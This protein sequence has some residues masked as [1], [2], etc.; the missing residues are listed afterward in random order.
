M[1]ETVLEPKPEGIDSPSAAGQQ[2]PILPPVTEL[3]SRAR[4][5]PVVAFNPLG[6]PLPRRDLSLDM[7]A[8]A[9]EVQS[10]SPP[11]HI[12]LSSQFVQGEERRQNGK[13]PDSR[14]S[15]AEN[16]SKS[17]KQD[18]SVSNLISS[19]LN[20]NEGSQDPTHRDNTVREFQEKS[21]RTSR[22]EGDHSPVGGDLTQSE[23]SSESVS[24]SDRVADDSEDEETS[25]LIDAE[26]NLDKD[27][28][29]AV[30]DRKQLTQQTPF[31]KS[32]I[33]DSNV[34]G[35]VRPP[36]GAVSKRSDWLACKEDSRSS[37]DALSGC[38]QW[39]ASQKSTSY[40]KPGDIASS[41]TCAQVPLSASNRAPS[42]SDAAMM[43]SCELSAGLSDPTAAQYPG[44]C[45]DPPRWVPPINP[46]SSTWQYLPDN[47]TSA[48]YH[49]PN[50]TAVDAQGNAGLHPSYYPDQLGACEDQDAMTHNQNGLSVADGANQNCHYPGSADA[51]PSLQSQL[52]PFST[53]DTVGDALGNIGA[54]PPSYEP[55]SA[56]KVSIDNIVEVAPAATTGVKEGKCF[57]N[58]RCL[59]RKA[60]W[61]GHRQGEAWTPSMEQQAVR[62]AASKLS[63]PAPSFAQVSHKSAIVDLTGDSD[64]QVADI[65]HARP[66]K[67][68][69]TSNRSNGTSFVTLAATALAGAVFGGFGVIAA[70]VSL[71]PDFFV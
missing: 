49:A 20:Q 29:P 68:V 57:N 70:L 52:P 27:S 56:K 59:K 55:D 7:H 2:P 10:A 1:Q 63:P 11:L 54:V 69:R 3:V 36:R 60:D 48:P 8:D 50:G 46:F 35:S 44:S 34:D 58:R 45:I 4:N 31:L 23:R 51:Q 28:E 39:A 37:N 53:F 42:P 9:K 22:R 14:N 30:K 32:E 24:S 66:V 17:S 41:Q 61:M 13:F 40:G 71:P 21:M 62:S 15:V 43:K 19:S 47:T 5:D 65:A 64:D 67:R 6:E 25:S 16:A 18:T 12:T 26:D 38:L 33:K